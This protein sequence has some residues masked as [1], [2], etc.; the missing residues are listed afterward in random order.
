[1]SWADHAPQLTRR[2]VGRSCPHGQTAAV[3]CGTCMEAED[4]IYALEVKVQRLTNTVDSVEDER[5]SL[6]ARVR[7]LEALVERLMAG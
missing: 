1:M 2:L 4:S 7:M 3:Y 5:D 6:E